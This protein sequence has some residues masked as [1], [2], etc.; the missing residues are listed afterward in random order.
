MQGNTTPAPKKKRGLIVV[1]AV[2]LLLAAGYFGLTLF[3]ENDQ[4]NKDAIL[5]DEL[6]VTGFAKIDAFS[7]TDASGNSMS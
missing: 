6:Q 7:Y 4:L 3:L 2:L 5:A 1:A